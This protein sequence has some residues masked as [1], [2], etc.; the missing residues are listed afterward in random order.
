MLGDHGPHVFSFANR[1][2][3]SSFES[4]AE[5]ILPKVSMFKLISRT[6]IG[7]PFWPKNVFNVEAGVVDCYN[8]T[9][10][11]RPCCSGA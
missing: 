10:Q 4:V 11:V 1:V 7:L 9:V 8:E 3:K 2:G 5:L 6:Q